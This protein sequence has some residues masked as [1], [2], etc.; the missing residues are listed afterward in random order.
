MGPGR[1]KCDLLIDT[2]HRVVATQTSH[3][4]RLRKP[5]VFDRDQDAV[6]PNIAVLKEKTKT[7]SPKVQLSFSR[8]E[9]FVLE[10]RPF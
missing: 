6:P 1:V 2:S 7:A 4:Y 5:I 10:N 3:L 8:V 9:F